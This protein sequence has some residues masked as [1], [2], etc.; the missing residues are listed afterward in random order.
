MSFESARQYIEEHFSSGWLDTSIA[1]ENV[2]FS[3]EE[4]TPWVRLT[5]LDA[6]SRQVSMGSTKLYRN[7]GVIV[8]QIFVPENTGTGDARSMADQVAAIFRG[9]QFNGIT[10]RAPSPRRVG[11]ANGWYQLNVSIPFFFDTN[12]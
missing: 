10:C 2:S 9:T 7:N 12:F 11:T 1:Y 4:G 6:D 3:P 8:V 5:I